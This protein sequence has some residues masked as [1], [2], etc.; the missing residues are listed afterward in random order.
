ML[1]GQEDAQ[2]QL[3]L[4]PLLPQ[5]RAT[6]YTRLFDCPANQDCVATYDLTTDP[7]RR[8]P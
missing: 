2:L 6:G 5:L 7:P 3:A 1:E 4:G 8:L